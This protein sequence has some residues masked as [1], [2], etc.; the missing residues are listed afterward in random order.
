[1]NY[2]S[3]LAYEETVVVIPSMSLA[4]LAVLMKVNYSTAP[5]KDVSLKSPMLINWRCVV[6]ITSNPMFVRDSSSV[7]IYSKPASMSS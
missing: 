6:L 4:P 2:T 3:R 1:M 7:I 5:S